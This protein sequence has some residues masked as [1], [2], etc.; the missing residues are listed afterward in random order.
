MLVVIDVVGLYDNIPP[1]EGVQCVAEV[2]HEKPTTRVPGQF[3][4]RLMQLILD[5][6]VFE[7]NQKKY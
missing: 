2:L 7:F 5:Y 3:I 1:T 4:T 6:S